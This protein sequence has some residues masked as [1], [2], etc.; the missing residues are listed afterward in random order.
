MRLDGIAATRIFYG[1]DGKVD[2]QPC[3]LAYSK[4][5]TAQQAIE[6]ILLGRTVFVTAED[7]PAVLAAVRGGTHA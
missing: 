1:R 4:P 2:A 5:M 6:R 7:A 3:I